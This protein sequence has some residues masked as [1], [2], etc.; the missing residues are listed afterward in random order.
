MFCDVQFICVSTGKKQYA[1]NKLNAKAAEQCE[2]SRKDWFTFYIS[3]GHSAHFLS[4]LSG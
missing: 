2:K 1:K 4:A 3:L